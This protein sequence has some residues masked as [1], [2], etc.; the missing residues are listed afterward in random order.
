VCKR[1]DCARVHSPR[2]HLPFGPAFI[3]TLSLPRLPFGC[4]HDRYVCAQVAAE[5]GN[6]WETHVPVV[7]A[8]GFPRTD[9]PIEDVIPSVLSFLSCTRHSLDFMRVQVK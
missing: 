2:S 4:S 5:V 6:F 8:E 3:L 7:D 1:S 9:I